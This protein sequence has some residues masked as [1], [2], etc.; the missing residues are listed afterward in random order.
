MRAMR[1]VL[2][3]RHPVAR[4]VAAA[5][6]ATAPLATATPAIADPDSGSVEL[7]AVATVLASDD[8]CA[9]AS[10]KKAEDATWSRSTLGLGRAWELSQG[11]GV[12]VAVVDS[13]VGTDIPALSGRVTAV[14]DAGEDCV[15][16]GSFA[17]G[18]IAAAPGKGVGVAGVAPGARILAVRGAQPRGGT[19]V[20]TLAA[21]IRTAVDKGADVI[22]VGRV[23]ATGKAELT[24]A[25]AYAAEHDALVVAPV[26]PDFLPRDRNTGQ[27][28][29][30]APWYWPASAPGVLSVIDYGPDGKRPDSAPALDGADLAAPGDAV[31]SVGP[32]GSGHYIGSG[33]SFAAAHVAGAAALVRAR[34]PEMSAAEVARQLTVAAYPSDTPRVDPYA[35]VSSLLTDKQGATPKPAAAHVPPAASPQPRHRALIVA[36]AGGGLLLLVAAGAVVIPRGRARRWR[37]GDA[38]DRQTVEPA[39]PT[40]PT[41]PAATGGS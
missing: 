15:G 26:G 24:K 30:P 8:P 2:T 18:L 38:R 35:A 9:K 16:H 28:A 7:P 11:A 19:T 3:H 4:A 1:R 32:K 27:P 40:Q 21:G 29:E 36:G 5:A 17:A 10:T 6:L 33:S 41:E 20:A 12:T 39:E 22:Y 37:P 23:L 13:G 34:Y 25:A 31:V 14:G